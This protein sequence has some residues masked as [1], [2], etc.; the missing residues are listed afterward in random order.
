MKKYSQSPKYKESQR[1]YYKSP[2]YKEHRRESGKKYY[3]SHRQQILERQKRY[4]QSP[5]YKKYIREYYK[6]RQRY[7]LSHYPADIQMQYLD[8]LWDQVKK[9][10]KEQDGK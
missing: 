1:R 4:H 7:G 3:Q 5:K 9:E 10:V 2:K 8:F 6:K